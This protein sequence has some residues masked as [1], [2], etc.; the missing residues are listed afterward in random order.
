[1]ANKLILMDVDGVLLEWEQAFDS[2]MSNQG[3]TKTSKDSY[4]VGSHYDLSEEARQLLIQ[5]FNESASMRYLEP[6]DGAVEYVKRLQ[7]DGNTI[8]LITSQS[9]LPMANRAR[10]DNLKEL[11][12]DIFDKIVFLDTGSS[13]DEA[14]SKY[15]KGCYWVED[16]PENAESGVKAGMIT[17]LYTQPHNKSFKHKDVTR[18]DTWKEVYQF[19][20]AK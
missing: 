16:K 19:I 12:G 4:D 18:C 20:S 14:L 9:L 3:Y 10:Q 2:W 7:Q 13:K 6:I 11:F 15:P 17:V 1:M 5:I 8:H